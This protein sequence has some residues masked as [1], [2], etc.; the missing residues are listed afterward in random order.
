[1]FGKQDQDPLQ[2]NGIL[3]ESLSRVFKKLQLFHPLPQMA[4]ERVIQQ[5]VNVLS[6]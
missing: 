3:R 4:A 5:E 1:M 6:S 2:P